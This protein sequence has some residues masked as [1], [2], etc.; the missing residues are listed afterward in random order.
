M[1]LL[2]NSLKSNINIKVP[3]FSTLAGIL[4]LAKTLKQAEALTPVTQFRM[5]F[6]L[7]FNSLI[8]PYNSGIGMANAPSM[9][10]EAFCYPGFLTST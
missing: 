5:M 9:M 2:L 4:C 7:P 10:P 8:R 3:S 6:F 1:P